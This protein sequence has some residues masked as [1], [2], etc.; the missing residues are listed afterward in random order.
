MRNSPIRESVNVNIDSPVSTLLFGAK[1]SIRVFSP[2]WHEETEIIILLKGDIQVE[3]GDVSQTAHAGDIIISNANEIHSGFSGENGAEY[4][5]FIINFNLISSENYACK[6][7]I[8][9]ITKHLIGFEHFITD[10]EL[11]N[12]AKFIFEVLNG[13]N[14]KNP[15]MHC[16]LIYYLVALLYEN[17]YTVKSKPQSNNKAIKEITEY[18][19][20]N[21]TQ[22]ITVKEI[23]D[24]FGYS[25]AYFCRFFKKYL[26][27]SPVKYINALRLQHAEKLL[28][29]TENSIGQIA[30]DSGFADVFYFS[31]VFKKQY[32]MSPTKFRE[33]RNLY[34]TTI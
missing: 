31:A 4:Y 12:K 33:N 16:G 21:Y 19:D 17:N 14:G 29:D 30:S 9:P 32:G 7:Y 24:K 18:I 13:E 28:L 10:S 5:V 23:S 11:F 20:T 27:I 34:F 6:K 2:H 25:E 8:E 22:K 15:L 1:G 3:I 26:G